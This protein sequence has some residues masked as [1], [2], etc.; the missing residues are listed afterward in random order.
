MGNRKILVTSALP[1]ANGSLHL[2]HLVEYIQTDVWVRNKK[3]KGDNCRYMCADD[4]HGTPI[5]ISAG[6]AG[7]SPEEYISAIH[8]QR[9]E[10]FGKFLVN[11]DNYYS[12]HS[13]ENKELSE[14][15]FL[16]MKDN[17]H[18]AE[19]EIS[20]MYCEKDH[21]FLPDRFIK[22]T[23]PKCGAE[24]QYGDSCEKCGITYDPSE[25][26]NPYC[27]VCGEKPEVK[28]TTHYFFKLGDF[29]E[30]LEEWFKGEHVQSEIL[31]KLSDWFKEGL[32]D[33]DI[34][35]DEP[36]FGFKIPGSD[37]KYFY[38]WVDAP[39]GYMASTK[40]WCS[41]NGEDFE[42]WWKSEDTDV[43]HFIGKDIVYFHCLFWPAMLMCSGYNT[44]KNVF[45]HGFLTVN[46]EKMSKSR[47]TFIKAS[48]FAR[49]INPEF[50]RYYYSCKL[51]GTLA[52]IDLN[53]EDFK[54]K[55]NS[56]IVGK[57]ANLGV[58]SSSILAKSLGSK[59]GSILPEDEDFIRMIKASK[60][61]IISCYDSLEYSKAMREICRLADIANK[62][63]EDSAPW[64]LAKTEPEKARAKIT[65]ILEAFRILML[66]IKPV[67]PA[68]AAIA[69]EN[70]GTGSMD[71]SSIDASVENREM[72]KMPHL[73]SRVESAQIEKMTE[74]TIAENQAET[75]KAEEKIEPLKEPIA[76]ECTIEDFMKVDL[77]VGT[78]KTAEHVEKAKKLLHLTVDIGGGITKNIFA[79]IKS[80][81]SPEDLIGTQVVVVANL[82]PRQMKFGL[83]EGMVIAAGEGGEEIF[84]LRPDKGAANGD[85][86]H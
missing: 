35:R 55:V 28:K 5:M 19:R 20:Q 67:M 25:L 83:S 77:R 56:D 31:K 73:A 23:C 45:V 84:V 66:Y 74:E 82:K 3:M 59:T 38:V 24:D 57:L 42:S 12:T 8:E 26:V 51:S 54:A 7:K 32:K 2:G 11:F 52:D 22:G 13:E 43:Y 30:R 71:W 70:L 15:I 9:I 49:N 61:E 69:E 65:A 39:I 29:K 33:W 18:I 48:T 75:K 1:Y 46:G 14:K 37:N 64:T 72:P 62:F 58:R 41:K 63:V 50:L 17:G 47:G 4:T 80:A 76:P 44:P 81:Y 21:M 27:S 79:G 53:F 16:S 60:D 68:M 10:D 6:K 86:I 40:N 34:S 36:Y 85:R 78:I